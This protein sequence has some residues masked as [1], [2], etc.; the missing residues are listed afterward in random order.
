MVQ[1]NCIELNEVQKKYGKKIVL[2]N[3]SLQIN[4]SEIFCLLGPSGSGKTTMVKLI[5]GIDTANKGE[6]HVLGKKM[7]D[8][9]LFHQIGYMAQADAL[10]NELTGMENLEFFASLYGL[11]GTKQTDRIMEVM[12]LVNLTSDLKTLVKKYS[13]GMR[14][15]L[16]LAIALLHA[17]SILI[18]DEPTVG[19]DPILRQSIWKELRKLSQSGTTIL[20][21]TH[22]MDEAERCDRLG[23]IYKG[24][25][26]AVD[27]PQ[28]LKQQIG[29]TS[30]EE[31]FL[32]YG[33]GDKK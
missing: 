18:L 31:A 1:S 13:G 25:L 23:M 7:P 8:L 10:Y 19:I 3:T 12:E 26:I 27:T 20:V 24:Q 28:Q 22:V 16:S 4:H 17:P 32:F 9:E 5:S 15:R 33:G 21:T 6:V 30:L 11:Q 29:V 14:R 2:Q